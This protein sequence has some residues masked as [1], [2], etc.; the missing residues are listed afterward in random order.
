MVLLWFMSST[1][2][3]LFS[4]KS[5][6]VSDLTFRTL[7][8]FEFIFVD[9]VRKFSNFILLQVAVQ[10]S[11]RHL[12]KRL[13]LP[14]CI[15][16]PPFS[17]IKYPYIDMNQPWIYKYSLSRSPLPSPFP[18]QPSGSSQCTS[19]EHLCCLISMCLCFLQFF[20]SCN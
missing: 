3:P 1:V 10:I 12:L 17:K 14:H 18:S 2:L 19:P 8:H 13:S 5:F 4:S 6:I 11:Q 9:G 15:V 16:L 20:F 7:I